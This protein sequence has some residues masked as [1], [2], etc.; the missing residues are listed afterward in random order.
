MVFGFEGINNNNA[1]EVAGL[2]WALESF[3]NAGAGEA[4]GV[5]A[6]MTREQY[7]VALTPGAVVFWD[8]CSGYAPWIAE[9]DAAALPQWYP[10]GTYSAPAGAAPVFKPNPAD[11]EALITEFQSVLSGVK[12][13]SFDLATEIE[14]GTLQIDL[15]NLGLVSVQ[16]QGTDIPLDNEGGQG[17]R[18]ATETE[19]VLEGQACDLWRQDTSTEI[20]FDFPCEVIVVIPK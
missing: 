11:Q 10:L 20:N 1:T 6:G 8:E 13:C 12:S 9:H 7:G 19:L 14:E 5:Q 18:M 15:N 16:V 3:A 2:T 4:V 17:W